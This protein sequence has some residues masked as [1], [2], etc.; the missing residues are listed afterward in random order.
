MLYE[1][2]K[3]LDEFDI[4]GAGMFGYVS[5]RSL[6][7]LILSLVIS[8]VAGEYFIKYMRKK[9]HI[10][11]ARDASIDPYGVQ[12]KGVPSMGGVVILAAVLVPALLLGKLSNVY[13]VLLIATIAFF[14]L[15]GFI[16]DKIKLGGNKDGMPPKL[17]LLAQFVFGISVG[18]TL[19]LSPDAVVRENVEREI[20][21]KVEVYHM[22][23][24]RKSTVTTVPFVKSN[25]I[26]Y[27]EVFNFI[28]DGKTKRACGWILFVLVTTFVIAAVSN[29]ANLNDGMDGMCAGNSA[30]IGVTLGIL[31]YVSGHIQFAGYLN[32]MYIPGTEEV[33]VF[34]SAF[35]GALVGFL[36]YNAYPAKVF[37][38]DTG[39]LA[40]GGV[41]A[42]T[43]II[44]HKELLLPIMCGIFLMESVSVMLQ[45]AYAKKGNARGEKWR[46]FKRAPFHD[47]Y[48]HRMEDGVKYLI[49]RPHGLLFESMITTRFWIVTILL[50]A[51]T[52]ITLKIR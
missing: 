45:V 24:S 51:I 40:I 30:I 22:S 25:N 26:D 9:K 14:G 15:I 1:L 21:E 50:A 5:F 16:D 28:Q 36:W 42:V 23:E 39:S 35:V 6:T 38:G 47:H 29:G 31:A 41:I 12:K 19:W 48:R 32:V 10:E 33:L 34:L 8:M 11:E 4:P 7:S 18:L 37:M 49:K 13:M 46:V 52:I 43:A 3:Y 27:Y 2:F 44:I 20:G 17:K